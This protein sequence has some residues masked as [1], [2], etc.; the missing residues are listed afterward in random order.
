[1]SISGPGSQPKAA[2]QREHPKARASP[3][4][5]RKPNW[6]FSN[7]LLYSLPAGV[8]LMGDRNELEIRSELSIYMGPEPNE[9]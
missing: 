5:R 6:V 4:Q 3:Y 2:T 9:N 8:H 1:M 7:P